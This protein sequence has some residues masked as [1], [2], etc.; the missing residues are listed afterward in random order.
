MT[1][2][3]RIHRSTWWA[4]LAIIATAALMALAFPHHAGAQTTKPC[5]R[6]SVDALCNW[7]NL[8]SVGAVTT[9]KQVRFTHTRYA[10]AWVTTRSGEP[11]MLKRVYTAL[12]CA[13]P[14]G[15][16]PTSVRTWESRKNY[17]NVYS[18]LRPI[19]RPDRPSG[20]PAS[21]AY[22]C[23]LTVS[24]KAYGEQ[25]FD[26]MIRLSKAKPSGKDGWDDNYVPP[27]LA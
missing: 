24:V 2:V 18:Q 16:K 4:I 26:V 19:G 8:D 23:Q 11:G 27:P 21:G 15:Y 20:L 25:V 10:Q 13:T 3:D 9:I 17:G 14:R 12:V 7:Y 6:T 5:T 1:F 22:D